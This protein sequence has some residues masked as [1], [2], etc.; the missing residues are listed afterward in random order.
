MQCAMTVRFAEAHS[1]NKSRRHKDTAKVDDTRTQQKQTT[2]GRNNKG[3]TVVPP[4]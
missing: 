1:R 3:D 2:Q 4:L